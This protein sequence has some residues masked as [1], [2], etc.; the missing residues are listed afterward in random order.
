M[1]TSLENI[2]VSWGKGQDHYSTLSLACSLHQC[3]SLAEVM[4]GARVGYHLRLLV[5]V[6]KGDLKLR[7]FPFYAIS[8]GLP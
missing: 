3:V 2:D 4:T 6:S 5:T 8:T 1:C 7:H